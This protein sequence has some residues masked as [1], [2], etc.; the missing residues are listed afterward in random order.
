[1]NS[2]ASFWAVE[3]TAEALEVTFRITL[4]LLGRPKS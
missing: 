2:D 1:M 3:K 4:P